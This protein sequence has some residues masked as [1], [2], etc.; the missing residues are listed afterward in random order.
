MPTVRPAPVKRSPPKTPV[1]VK[2]TVLSLAKGLRVLES[3][4]PREP[5]LTLTQIAAKTGLDAGTAFRVVKTFLMLGYL[6]QAEGAKRYRLAMKVLDLGFNALSAMDLHDSS[7]PILRSLVGEVSEAASLSVL[8]GAE[9]VYIERVQAGWTRLGVNIRIGSR[10]PA[11]CTAAG[12]AILAHLPPE[13]RLEVLRLRER[14]KLTPSTP[15][16]IAEIEGRCRKARE[17][18]YA[19]SDQDTVPG[20]RVLG[21]PILDADGHPYGAVSVASPSIACP[22]DDFVATSAA[23]LVRAAADLSRILRISGAASAA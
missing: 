18:G 20:L 19:L 11:Y 15:V 3:F 21:A 10:I 7:R 2:S 4:E 6:R 22:L 16:T 12:I 23:P 13:R 17:L 14:V 8:E 5:E 1:S 9:V